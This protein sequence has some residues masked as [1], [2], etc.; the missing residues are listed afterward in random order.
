MRNS[1]IDIMQRVLEEVLELRTEVR[2]LRVYETVVNLINSTLAI[3]PETR[4][5]T[6]DETY[7]LRKLIEQERMRNDCATALVPEPTRESPNTDMYD[8]APAARKTTR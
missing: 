2:R 8:D 1:E 5:A 6:V 7:T 3:P 4:G